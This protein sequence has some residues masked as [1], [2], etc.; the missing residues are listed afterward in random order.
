M[1]ACLRERDAV[2]TRVHGGF[3]LALK[4]GHPTGLGRDFGSSVSIEPTG[5]RTTGLR[6]V[7]VGPGMRGQLGRLNGGDGDVQRSDPSQSQAEGQ[8]GSTPTAPKGGRR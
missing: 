5:W 7:E 8:V 3:D 6:G 1:A 2:R 4:G